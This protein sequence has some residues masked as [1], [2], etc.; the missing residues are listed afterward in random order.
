M[1][2]QFFLASTFCSQTSETSSAELD[3][4]A[5]IKQYILDLSKELVDNKETVSLRE[6]SGEPTN[7]VELKVDKDE[8][9]KLIGRKGRTA[10]ALRTVLNSAVAH[11]G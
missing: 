10:D 6:T 5:R 1:T 2:T 4:C 9:G 7:V 8:I 11:N 3:P